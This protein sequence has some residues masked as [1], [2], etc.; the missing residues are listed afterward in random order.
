MR[1]RT[2]ISVKLSMGFLSIGFGRAELGCVYCSLAYKE[3]VGKSPVLVSKALPEWGK[4]IG[5]KSQDNRSKDN[6]IATYLSKP[7][8]SKTLVTSIQYASYQTQ[9]VVVGFDRPLLRIPL[10][11]VLD[12]MLSAVSKN[13]P[14]VWSNLPKTHAQTHT[15]THTHT[16]IHHQQTTK[17]RH[18]TELGGETDLFS[19]KIL[20]LSR[21]FYQSQVEGNNNIG[22]LWWLLTSCSE[23]NSWVGWPWPCWRPNVVIMYQIRCPDI[24]LGQVC[25]ILASAKVALY[26]EKEITLSME[27]EAKER[28]AYRFYFSLYTLQKSRAAWPL[29]ADCLQEKPFV[30][31]AGLSHLMS[32]A[33]EAIDRAEQRSNRLHSLEYHGFL[34]ENWIAL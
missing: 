2:C 11:A 5:F 26:M 19:K 12:C 32:K 6:G 4:G 30:G 25:T 9:P 22:V 33:S 28:K 20:D 24:I 8:F 14:I 34:E 16:H 31:S 1:S 15:H 17:K 13:A 3:G 7:P 21:C 23:L 10:K 18:K 29:S 27:D